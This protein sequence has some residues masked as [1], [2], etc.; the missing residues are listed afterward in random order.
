MH[1]QFEATNSAVILILLTDAANLF[2]KIHVYRIVQ[3][4]QWIFFFDRV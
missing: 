4:R 2:D 1:T 3:C